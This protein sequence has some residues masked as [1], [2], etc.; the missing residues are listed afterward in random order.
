MVLFRVE[1]SN[2]TP[3]ELSNIGDHSLANN[4]AINFG[5]RKNAGAYRNF[6]VGMIFYI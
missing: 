1:I 5:K 4:G 6:K 3:L 2:A